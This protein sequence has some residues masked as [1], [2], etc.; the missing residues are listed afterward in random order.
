MGHGGTR[1]YLAVILA[2]S[3]ISSSRNQIANRKSPIQ[4]RS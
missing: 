4:K 1:P 2:A 3:R